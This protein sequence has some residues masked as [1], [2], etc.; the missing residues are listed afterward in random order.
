[1]LTY[2]DFLDEYIFNLPSDHFWA[3]CNNKAT[4]VKTG[5]VNTQSP[6][7][8]N[9]VD[10]SLKQFAPFLSHSSR[11]SSPGHTVPQQSKE[12]SA[13][14]ATLATL[15]AGE[16]SGTA[17]A[18]VPNTGLLTALHRRCSLHLSSA[19]GT[20]HKGKLSDRALTAA[21]GRWATD[22]TLGTLAC[23]CARDYPSSRIGC[24]DTNSKWTTRTD[25]SYPFLT[26]STETINCEV[27][28]S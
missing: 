25:K 1:M 4:E 19:P 26:T 15:W 7:F 2:S 5:V 9:K 23:S 17:L 28:F 21:R 6:K 20:G 24:T 16:P 11:S 14:P 12:Q 8:R 22:S 18:L 27:S 13:Q 3:S 10:S